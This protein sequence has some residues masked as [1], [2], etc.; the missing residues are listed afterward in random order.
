[1]DAE[2][3]GG[4]APAAARLEQGG[5]RVGEPR[6]RRR[7]AQHA[8]DE[9]LERRVRKREQELEQTAGLV[10]G[11]G[12]RGRVDRGA[13]L[14]ERAAERPALTRPADADASRRIRVDELLG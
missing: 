9:R 3:V 8:V 7:R 14:D 2:P 11:D 12:R 13:G 5:K 4:L 6:I 1:M 10:R